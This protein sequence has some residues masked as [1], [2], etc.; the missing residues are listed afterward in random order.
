MGENIT[1]EYKAEVQAIFMKRIEELKGD[2][3]YAAFGEK[4]GLDTSVIYN[5]VTGGRVP[6]M[7]ALKKIAESCDVSVDW[8]LGIDS[9]Q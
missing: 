3:T 5:Y 2:M 4:V 7:A 1:P 9:R 6:V 8:L